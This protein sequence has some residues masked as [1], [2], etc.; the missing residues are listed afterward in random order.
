MQLDSTYVENER[1]DDSNL[2]GIVDQI[3]LQRCFRVPDERRTKDDGQISGVDLKDEVFVREDDFIRDEKPCSIHTWTPLVE[4]EHTDT[5]ASRIDDDPVG[6]GFVSAQSVGRDD[7][8]SD[9]LR[10]KDRSVLECSLKLSF[11]AF[12]VEQGAQ[13]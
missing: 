10:P 7:F 6:R 1:F 9:S 2:L 5:S 12:N 8:R 11:F 13:T 4:S 3:R